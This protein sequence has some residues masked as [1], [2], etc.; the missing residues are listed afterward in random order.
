M[1]ARQGDLLFVGCELPKGVSIVERVDGRLLLSLGTATGHAHAIH[2]PDAKLYAA[3]PIRFIMAPS[4]VQ[5]V[6]D[7]HA[8]I[9][10]PAG[11]YRVV[12]QKE[13]RDEASEV[14]D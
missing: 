14:E 3:G 7:E 2:T 11:T 13:W 9:E 8:A 6:H 12:R 1:Q 10:L 5:V 4:G